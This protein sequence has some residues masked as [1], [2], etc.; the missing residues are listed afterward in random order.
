[1]QSERFD[2]SF[3]PCNAGKS[4]AA[5]IAMMATTTKS[6]MR[7]KHFLVKVISRRCTITDPTSVL[8]SQSN[9][10][11]E[12]S[13]RNRLRMCRLLLLGDAVQD[14]CTAS[15]RSRAHSSYCPQLRL[16]LR[17]D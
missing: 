12:L 17:P 5:R 8:C 13:L 15:I 14:G 3:A 6:S 11:G 10:S 7:V 4:I 9:L 2:F 16:H 1:M